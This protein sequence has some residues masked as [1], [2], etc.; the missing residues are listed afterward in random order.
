MKHLITSIRRSSNNWLSSNC[1]LL[2]GRPNLL[3]ANILNAESPCSN[4]LKNGKVGH[5]ECWDGC[6]TLSE[7]LHSNKAHIITYH[8]QYFGC[9]LVTYTELMCICLDSDSWNEQQNEQIQF[10]RKIYE[11][12]NNLSATESSARHEDIDFVEIEWFCVEIKC[13]ILYYWMANIP[14][15]P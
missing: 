11:L 7:F 2:T 10:C 1:N 13:K 6:Q 4:G 12:A 5:I 14:D 9:I 8:H 3:F 15:K